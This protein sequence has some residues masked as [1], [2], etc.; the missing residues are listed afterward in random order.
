MRNF[1][2]VVNIL[3]LTL[4]FLAAEMQNPD[5]N[6]PEKNEVVYTEQRILYTPPVHSILNRK[7]YEPSYYHYRPSVPISPSVYYPFLVKLLLL[8]SPAQIS[9]WQPMTNFPQ[10]VAVPHPVPSPSFLAIPTNEDHDSAAIPTIN[11]ITPIVSTPVPTT[12]SV[13]NTEAN[14]EASTASTNIPETTTVPVTSPAI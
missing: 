12:E 13:M 9:K 6:C 7:H 3:A 14:P 1:I 4:P 10:P 5:S 2:V 11:T 8:S